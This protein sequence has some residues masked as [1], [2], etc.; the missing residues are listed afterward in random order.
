MKGDAE[1]IKVLGA[2]LTAELTSI[3]QYFLHSE[4]CENWRYT[5]LAARIKK[6]AI[7]EMKHAEALIERILYLDGIPDV[8]S[9]SPIRIG[10]DIPQI[11][12]ND[13]ALEQEAVKRLNDGIL[14]CVQRGDNGSREL[15]VS[16]LKDEEEH[17]DWIEAQIHQIQAMGL[18]NYLTTIVEGE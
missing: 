10:K 14:T 7:D 18:Q 9:Y 16:I 2:V 8:Q 17:I 12:A 3:N 11:Y 1:V 15:L 5:G 4:M 13:L 6:E